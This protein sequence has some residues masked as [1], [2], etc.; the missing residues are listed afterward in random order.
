MGYRIIWSIDMSRIKFPVLLGFSLAMILPAFAQQPV[1]TS[2]TTVT[3]PII[4]T[5][6][7]T[8]DEVTINNGNGN[9]LS[10]TINVDKNLNDTN[11]A[12]VSV[13]NCGNT[14]HIDAGSSAIC[15]SSDASSPVSFSSDSPTSQA[16]GT[17]TIKQD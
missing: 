14:T 15:T 6:K 8:T 4:W 2:L 7:N 10:I 11:T 1:T 3:S 9:K 16:S 5:S 12:G 17:Y 13:K